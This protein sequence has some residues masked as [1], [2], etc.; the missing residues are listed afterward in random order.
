MDVRIVGRD[1]ELAATEVFLSGLGDGSRALLI[2]GPAGIGKTVVWRAAVERARE[3]GRRVC[4]CVA[5]ETDARLAFVGLADLIGDLVGDALPSLPAPQARAVE[6][7]LLRIHPE[8]GP[9]ES[10]AIALG[11]L[12][13]LRTLAA[14]EPLV[15]AVDDIHW[16]DA[17]SARVLA[18]VGRRLEGDD[19]RFLLTRRTGVVS[20]VEQALDAAAALSRLELRSLSVGATAHLLAS[21]LGLSLPR[22]VVR[23]VVD[24]TRGNPLFA[25]EIG[26][27]I[28]EQ[29]LPGIVDDL[30]VPD[31]VEDLLGTRVQR[32]PASMR[33]LLL[34]V[35]LDSNLTSSE[36]ESL[37]GRRALEDALEEGVL[38]LD[39]GRVRASHPLLAAAAKKHS[40]AAARRELHRELARIVHDESLRVLHLALASDG[41]DEE[42]ACI[43]SRAAAGAAG[44]GARHEAV[45]LAE[46][47]LRLSTP[48][49]SDRSERLI[50]LAQHLDAAG[51]LRRV[52]AL[53]VP[54]AD[55]LPPGPVRARA[56]LLLAS[57][58]SHVDDFE[59][60]LERAYVESDQD[61]LL[62]SDVLA[63]KA[64]GFA[65]G[66]VERLSEAEACA[67]E[68]LALARAAGG[69]TPQALEA[70]AWTRILAG[71]PLDDL[72]AQ[73]VES[74]DGPLE[75]F[76]SL[77]RVEGVRRAFRGEVEAAREIFDRLLA[78][79]DERGEEWSYYALRLQL[80]ELEL[81][82]G[83]WDEAGRLLDDWE[84]SP[85]E[86]ITSGPAYARCSALLAAGRG[87]A[88]DGERLATEA[89]ARAEAT[90]VRWDRLE[91]LR[92]RGLFELHTGEPQRAVESFGAVWDHMRTH[93]I[94]D[95]GAFPVAPDLVEAL[96]EL[97]RLDD[98]MLVT[99]R[100]RE[101]S[102]QQQHPWGLA[103]SA[104]CDAVVRLALGWD[105]DAAATLERAAA[106]YESLGLRFDGARSLL[107]L[108]RT[109]RRH[110]KW[111]AA[112]RSL[113][114][115]VAAF[116]EL[117]ATG[118]AT[119][120]R[121]EL[122]RVAARP[123]QPHGEL[124]STE[125]RVVELAA[126]GLANKEIARDLFIS[127]KT[128]ER[129]LS[130]AYAKLGVRS[131]AQLARRLSQG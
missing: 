46:H 4:T 118:W 96:A 50:A 24:A 40:R 126:D 22:R 109:Q 20:V 122:A 41:P 54:E 39:G 36:L 1:E 107:A 104:R 72:N 15:L 55:R 73:Y 63:T 101:L 3:A 38:V 14:S 92:A 32:L 111:G 16:L 10:R 65:I 120:A 87:L 86:G 79:A 88:E 53:L 127:V 8:G 57:D 130:H 128:V 23:E 69:P 97:D 37:A 67:L 48:E 71:R 75:V 70:L 44:R 89:L 47:A 117:G 42:L 28:A 124:T 68:S 80:C 116:E 60:H 31:S 85:D 100:L 62:R 77:Q 45:A 58:I 125:R 112:R 94:D 18:F 13:A 26:R 59:R 91:S 2:E 19:V 81:R 34:A 121:S 64:A 129:H 78:L 25:L 52:T 90:G 102:E 49:S 123:P 5:S 17:P 74:A 21:R 82:A 61:Q 30:P 35:A 99:D 66:L 131:R 12:N 9:P 106:N 11:F 83:G 76:H 51:E 119:S 108:G 93:G 115:A 33:R 95:P 56:H 105:D 110:R 84:P 113:E 6:I 7:A 43:A 98:A 27:M 29:G 103:G 114:R